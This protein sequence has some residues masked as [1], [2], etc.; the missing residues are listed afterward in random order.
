MHDGACALISQS[1]VGVRNGDRLDDG[2]LQSD[3]IGVDDIHCS[4]SRN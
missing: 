1:V 3:G 2:V 4:D